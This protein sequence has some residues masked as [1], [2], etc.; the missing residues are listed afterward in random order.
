MSKKKPNWMILLY[1]F[2]LGLQHPL[3]GKINCYTH[4]VSY[5]TKSLTY[6][7]LPN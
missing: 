2:V 5:A 7:T 3:V 1:L 6:Y 4:K